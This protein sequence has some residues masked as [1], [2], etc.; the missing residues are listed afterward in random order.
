MGRKKVPAELV[1]EEI[2]RM[3]QLPEVQL[4]RKE[5]RLINRRRIELSR[6]KWLEKR[7]R[8][9]MD[10]GWTYDTLELLFRQGEG[11]EDK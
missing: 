9:L 11:G 10:Q 8:E 2:Q 6:L 5:Q 7:G 4:A 1:E 3:N